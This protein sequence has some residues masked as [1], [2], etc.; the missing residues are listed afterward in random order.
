MGDDGPADWVAVRAIYALV[1][2]L[3]GTLEYD[4]PNV[5]RDILQLVG[6]DFKYLTSLSILV[7]SLVVM[8]YY[9]RSWYRTL[10]GRHGNSPRT[11]G[12]STD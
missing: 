9:Y 6:L 11:L 3:Q 7:V 12:Y 5:R 10:C 2:R 4:C 8:V 1:W